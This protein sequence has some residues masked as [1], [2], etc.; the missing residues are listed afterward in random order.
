VHVLQP[1]GTREDKEDAARLVVFVLELVLGHAIAA[2]L[3][4][5]TVERFGAAVP[6]QQQIDRSRRRQQDQLAVR[7][8]GA[9]HAL[10]E[11]RRGLTRSEP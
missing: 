11:S 8:D 1:S 3:L 9:A 6:L 4:V 2:Q 7:P 10:A 5:E